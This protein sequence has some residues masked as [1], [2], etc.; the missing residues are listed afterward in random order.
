[1]RTDFVTRPPRLT[2][3]D[4]RRIWSQSETKDIPFLDAPDLALVKRTNREKDHSVIGELARLMRAPADRLRHS[5]SARELAELAAAH[6]DVV[7]SLVSERALLARLDRSRVDVEAALDAERRELM[8]AN[9]RRL[10]SYATAA[11]R[12]RGRWPDA[13]RATAG[14][15]LLEAHREIVRLAEGVLPFAPSR[16]SA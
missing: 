13:E 7:R 11:E 2:A 5:R 6:P 15:P 9:E 12:W 8:H 1:V 14:R 16:G 4:L 10:E 3:D